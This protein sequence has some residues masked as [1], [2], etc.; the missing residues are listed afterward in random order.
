MGPSDLFAGLNLDDNSAIDALY[1]LPPTNISS[2][3]SPIPSESAVSQSTAVLGI[4]SGSQG[5]TSIESSGVEIAGQATKQRGGSSA[6]TTGTKRKRQADIS[7]SAPVAGS[8]I[9]HPPQPFPG[10]VP[11]VAKRDKPVSRGGRGGVRRG[12]G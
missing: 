6:P 5:S 7:S 4:A 1:T 11:T 12:R 3:E 10:M 8:R 9:R 2:T